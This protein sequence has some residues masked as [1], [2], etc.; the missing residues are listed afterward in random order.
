MLSDGNAGR[1]T[2]L[3]SIA[4]FDAVESIRA[5]GG[6]EFL[7]LSRA[8]AAMDRMRIQGDKRSDRNN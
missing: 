3:L 6:N 2:K 7:S 8:P 4:S 5:T 1:V